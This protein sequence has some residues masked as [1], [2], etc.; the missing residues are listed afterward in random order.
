MKI[1]LSLLLV[2]GWL[3]SLQAQE[4]P[5]KVKPGRTV[6][7]AKEAV[8]ATASPSDSVEFMKTFKELY[9]MI[10]PTRSVK[11][12]A[13]DYLNR[14][15]RSFRMQGIDS[16]EAVKIAMTNLDTN[17]F[18]KIYLD[19]YRKNLTAKE[20]KKYLEF[21]KTPEGRKISGILPNLQR[22]STDANAYISRT[23]NTNL[24]PLRQEASKKMLKERPPKLGT[25]GGLQRDSTGRVIP[26]P[27]EPMN[28]GAIPP[29]PQDTTRR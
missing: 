5:A 29:V 3:A 28:P 27:K 4:K 13:E 17:A 24:T 1:L 7:P 21:L 20:L 9:P 22:A 2:F 10:A 18:Y 6:A 15:S 25:P 23:V 12:E 16:V 14:I 11:L 26:P 8:A 19:V